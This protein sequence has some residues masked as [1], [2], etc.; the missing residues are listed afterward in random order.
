MVGD[1]PR[2]LDRAVQVRNTILRA[3]NSERRK[4]QQEIEKLIQGTFPS[5]EAEIQFQE[6]IRKAASSIFAEETRKLQKSERP[7]KPRRSINLATAGLWLIVLGVAGF[8]F[9]MPALGA[10]ALVCGVAAIVWE[11][12]LKPRKQKRSKTRNSSKASSF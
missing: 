10:A 11:T 12:V 6:Q 9:W 7:E 5:R 2:K 3:M 1:H 8:V 4:R